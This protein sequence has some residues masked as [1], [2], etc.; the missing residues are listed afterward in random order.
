MKKPR[1]NLY[2][3]PQPEY[4]RSLQAHVTMQCERLQKG[5]ATPTQLW[6]PKTIAQ[7]L[8][9]YSE[10]FRATHTFAGLRVVET[11]HWKNPQMILVTASPKTHA[12]GTGWHRLTYRNK[13][14][15]VRHAGSTT[16]SALED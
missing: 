7:R 13:R 6:V 2:R 4:L 12:R 5:G 3:T 16:L 14:A 10:E 11:R 9:R 1:K 8:R 15:R